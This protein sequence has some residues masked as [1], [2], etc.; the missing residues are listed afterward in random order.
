MYCTAYMFTDC[1]CLVMSTEWMTNKKKKRPDVPL[2][3]CLS[4]A[5]YV[6]PFCPALKTNRHQQLNSKAVRTQHSLPHSS[7]ELWIS[8]QELQAEPEGVAPE[9]LT[10]AE[11]GP[12]PS[13][14]PNWVFLVPIWAYRI[15]LTFQGQ[16]VG[17]PRASYTDFLPRLPAVRDL[18]R[19]WIQEH[20]WKHNW[21]GL[22]GQE[23][24]TCV[25]PLSRVCIYCS[26][27]WVAWYR[28]G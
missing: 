6:L 25:G 15:T 26:L 10:E 8:V 5:V 12:C 2:D 9:G 18:L 23:R 24:Q 28:W 21:T 19:P 13:P 20:S 1:I 7:P 4:P 16:V 11:P 22:K 3:I 27:K 17:G 14:P